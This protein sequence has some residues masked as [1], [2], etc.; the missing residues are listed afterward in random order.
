MQQGAGLVTLTANNTYTGGTSIAT[1]TLQI[2]SG[3][4]TG[5]IVGDVANNGTLQFD[6]ANLIA[7]DDVISGS[8]QLRQIGTGTLVLSGANTYSGTTTVAS[9]SLRIGNGGATGSLGTGAMLLQPGT[10]LEFNRSNALTVANAIS[11]SGSLVQA[12]AGTTTLAGSANLSAGPGTTSVNAGAL[13]VTGALTSPVTVAAGA[14]LGGTG[15]V[16][17]SVLVNAGAA[18]APGAAGAGTLTTGHLTL[19]SGSLLAFHLG[20]PGVIGGTENDL[21][22]VSGNLSIHGTTLNITDSAAFAASPGVYRLINYS[23]TLTGSAANVTIGTA[24][25]FAPSDVIVQTA[26]AQQVNLITTVPGLVVSF[27]DGGGA[28]SD[29]IVAGGSGTWSAAAG[30]WT[31]ASGSVNSGWTPG[32]AVFSGATGTVTLGESITADGLQ[33][34]STGYVIEGAG[35]TLTLQSPTLGSAAIR[36]D[37]GVTATIR[38]PLAGAVAVIKSDPGTVVLTAANSYSGGT[39]VNAGTLQLG[40]GGTAGSVTGDV[41]NHGQLT[42]FRSNAMTLAGAISGAGGFRQSGPGTTTLTGANTYAGTTTIAAGVLQVGNGGTT[43]TLGLGGVINDAVLTF[44]RGDTLM[45]SNDISG[46]GTV[47]QSGAGTTILTGANSYAGPTTIT[48]GALQIG[49]GGTTGTLGPGA[50]NNAGSLIFNRADALTVAN[51]ITGAG[52][53]VQAGPGATTLSGLV[54]AGSTDIRSGTLIVTGT[55]ASPTLLTGGGARLGGTGTI[56]GAVTIAAGGM[57]APGTSPGTLTVGAL[58]MLA[59]AI[60]DYELA[61]PGVAGGGINDLVNVTGDLT[62]AATLN[63]TDIGGFGLGTYRLM[64]YG[65]T[66]VNNGVAFGV[67]PLG[68]LYALQTSVAAQVNLVVTNLSATPDPI[69]IYNG[70]VPGAW[71]AGV[72]NWLNPIGSQSWNGQTAS[73]QNA[74]GGPVTVVGQQAVTGLQFPVSGYSLVAGAAASIATATP[75]TPVTLGVGT[76]TLIGAPIVGTGGLD[77]S[78]AGTLVLIANNTYAGG[79]A[80]TGGSGAD[81]SVQFVRESGRRCRQQ[82]R[83]D[84]QPL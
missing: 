31:N 19:A 10:T 54:S 63:V 24:P 68:F 72:A 65:G 64:N 44:K 75:N 39:T 38:A 62:I 61:T 7:Y 79:S 58:T 9:G 33:F 35:H 15:T 71:Q 55:L 2:G 8:G 82:R 77:I 21:L 81:R 46:T 48:A 50:V 84:F 60:A 53:I 32:L 12:G 49:S 3:G 66:F 47:N 16:N 83:A 78:G 17:G 28:P 59:G 42:V 43:G 74:P 52:T 30:N 76:T 25:G 73:F 67:M 11:G 4:T 51:A 6:R 70:G 26:V 29:G 14:T 36:A 41:V 27:W 18:L 5:A 23:G 37:A 20:T 57:L 45:S 80:I 34:T 69:L 56:T 22:S 1:G 13:I 40:D